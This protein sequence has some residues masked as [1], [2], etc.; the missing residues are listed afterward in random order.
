MNLN[1]GIRAIEYSLGSRQEVGSDLLKSNPEWNL[2]EIEGKTGV[3]TRH[4]SLRTETALDIGY[5]ASRKLEESGFDFKSID[6]LIFVTQSPD[7]TLPTTACLLQDKLGLSTNC[8]A[9]DVNLGCSGF[10]YGLATSIALINASMANR[11]LLVCADTYTKY[12]AQN[13]RTCR[14]IFSDGAAAVIIEPDSNVTTGP[15]VF[16]TDGSGG[17]N[18]IV[19]GSGSREAVSTLN[20]PTKNL[21][22]SGQEIF[23]FTIKSIP[24]VVDLIVKKSNICIEDIDLFVFHQASK[25]VLTNIAKILKIPERKLFSNLSEIGNTVSATIPI[26][27]LDASRQSMLVGGQTV[28]ICGFGVGYSWAGTV[29][30]WNPSFNQIRQCT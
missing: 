28:L 15:F 4:L 19:R 27:L 17:E 26:A 7:Y 1:I 16:G 14:P 18:L 13:D 8:F 24:K 3:K 22:M 9:Y 29:L 23:M 25:L 30:K 6:A 20:M 11:V 12:I 21:F 2:P 10:V 5:R